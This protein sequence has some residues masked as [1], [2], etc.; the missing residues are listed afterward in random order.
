MPCSDTQLTRS[1]PCANKE[2]N[3]SNI[4]DFAAAK[5]KREAAKETKRAD[6]QV[7]RSMDD[8]PMVD[9]NFDIRVVLG[10]VEFMYEEPTK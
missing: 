10:K 3:L 5:A 7:W 9:G 1:V 2:D 4:I 8:L 6:Q